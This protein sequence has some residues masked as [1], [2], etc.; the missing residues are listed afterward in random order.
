MQ[1][2]ELHPI[3]AAMEP[4]D[5]RLYYPDGDQKTFWSYVLESPLY[6]DELAEIRREGER[7]NDVPIPELTYELFSIYARTGSRLEYERVYFERRRILNTAVL[8]ALLEPGQEKHLAAVCEIV[9]SI[10]NEYTWCLPAHLGDT[11]ITETIDL[12]SAETGFALS[13]INCLLGERLPAL[14]QVR[15]KAEV[16][17]RLFVPYLTCGPYHWETSTH[18]WSAVCSGSIGSAALLLMEDKETLTEILFKVQGSMEYYLQGFGEDGA[19][20]EGLGYWNYGFGYFV[21]YADLLRQ[22]SRGQLDWFR[23]EKVG[24]IAAFQQKCFLGGQ[25]VANFSDSLESGH[26]F[27]GLSYY[28]A[29]AYPEVEVPPLSLRAAYTEDHCSRW[30]PALRNLI[31]CKPEEGPR[32]W[33]SASYYL[34]DAQWLLSRH[35]GTDG[36]FGF[37][38]KGGNNDEPHNHNDLGGF[39]LQGEGTVYISELGSGEY[40]SGYFGTE[41]YSYDCNGSQGHSVPIIDGQY[42]VA[43]AEACAKVQ[44]AKAGDGS[45]VLE[46][47]L[48][49][50]YRVDSLEGLT[51]RFEWE[52]GVNPPVL[53]MTDEFRFAEAPAALVERFIT[54]I[55]PVLEEDT[56]LLERQGEGDG[57]ADGGAD[58]QVDG[59]ADGQVDGRADGQVDGQADG[60][61]DGQVDEKADGRADGQGQRGLRISYDIAALKPEISVHSYNDHFGKVKTWYGLDFYARNPCKHE[62]Y[63]FEFRFL[64]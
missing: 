8:L 58:G 46:L 42:Q 12:F 5:V 44:E 27:L 59:R 7:L 31:W 56:V 33:G 49:R 24:S 48:T 52:T 13:E 32:D 57:Q 25:L 20:L 17:K 37:A 11:G 14:L 36:S 39:I 53:A 64:D 18:N 2:V 60:R 15:I 6:C 21:Y 29:S 1:R 38:A 61:A 4:S 63:H 19:C 51:R 22:K 41:R 54:F 28:L 43:G 26:V 62:R 3:I 35:S 9:W 47:D 23:R 45:D 30:A 55:P 16:D 40:T 50:A 34:P 10:C